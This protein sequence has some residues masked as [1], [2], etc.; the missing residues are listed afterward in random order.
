VAEVVDPELHLVPVDRLALWDA[1]DA[2]VV[3]QQIDPLVRGE[4]LLSGLAHGRLRSEVE[5]DNL[6]RRLADARPD[7]VH[8]RSR[9]VLIARGHDD[10]RA[11][12]GQRA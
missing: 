6:E 12:S 5:R 7:V 10:V 3:D 1:H 11:G 8:R 2:C 4:D 9:L